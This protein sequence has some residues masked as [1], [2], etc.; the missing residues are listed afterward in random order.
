[1]TAD[2]FSDHYIVVEADLEAVVDT[3][4]EAAV[5]TAAEPAL[6]VDAAQWHVA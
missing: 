1:M 5:D 6:A 3:V 4:A 2:W